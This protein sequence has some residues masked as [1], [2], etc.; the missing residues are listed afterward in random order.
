MQTNLEYNRETNTL[1]GY[2]IQR[3][4]KSEQ[5]TEMNLSNREVQ[6]HE[7]AWNA[8]KCLDICA[9][10]NCMGCAMKW[11]FILFECLNIWIFHLIWTI[12]SAILGLFLFLFF[13]THTL[14]ITQ[15][16]FLFFFFCFCFVSFS[17]IWTEFYN[18]LLLSTSLLKYSRISFLARRMR[19]LRAY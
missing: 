11:T 8:H 15:F 6:T 19:C 18:L 13:H 4:T 14:I 12:S 5:K 1:L 10:F 7:I 17:N 2:G 16:F 9:R 3:K